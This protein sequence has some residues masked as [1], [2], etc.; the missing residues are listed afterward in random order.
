LFTVLYTIFRVILIPYAYYWHIR[1]MWN[2]WEII[3]RY[4]LVCAIITDII[5]A[6]ISVM[7]YYW[8]YLI[9]KS[10]AVMFGILKKK[11]TN[12]PA[13]DYIGGSKEE[14]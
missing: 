3:P 10:M 8:Y 14:K 6:A 4:M 9:L 5:W 11:K 2:W 12:D 1:Y 13:D 7:N